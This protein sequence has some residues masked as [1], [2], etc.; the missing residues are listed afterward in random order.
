MSALRSLRVYDFVRLVEEDGEALLIEALKVDLVLIL[1]TRGW[2]IIPYS[3]AMP[4]SELALLAG[5]AAAYPSYDY[6]IFA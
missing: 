3:S 6:I 2:S 1:F 5:C 4:I